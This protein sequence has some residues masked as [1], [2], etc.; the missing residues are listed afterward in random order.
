[1]PLNPQMTLQS[2]EKWAIDF[3]GLIKPQGKTGACYIITTMEYLT[4]WVE[5]QPVKDCTAAAAAK[6][7]FDNVLTR[8]GY[9]KI[10]MSDRGTYFLNETINALIEEFQV[11][12]QKS[13]PYHPQAN[14][15]VEAFKKL[16]EIV[17]TKVC[18][19]RLGPAPTCSAMGL[20]NNVQET[21]GKNTFSVSLWRGSCHANG[22]YRT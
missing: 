16:L 18:N 3:V 20:Q 2:F 21:D 10:L 6:F 14:G 1:M 4:R 11:Y 9:P 8:F 15:T 19:A 12:H 22:I 13:T 5:A 17:L 7:L